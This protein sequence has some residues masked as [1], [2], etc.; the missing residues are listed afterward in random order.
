LTGATKKLLALTALAETTTGLAL[1]V[2]PPIVVRVLLGAAIA[3]LDDPAAVR[4][5]IGRVSV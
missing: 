2:Y 5:V 4:I 3:G 1:L